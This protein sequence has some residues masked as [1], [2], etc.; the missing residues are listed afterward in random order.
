MFPLCIA[1]V[2]KTTGRKLDRENQTEHI[3]EV[4]TGGK[5]LISYFIYFAGNAELCEFVN[6]YFHSLFTQI[7]LTEFFLIRNYAGLFYV[8]FCTT[9]T[10]GNRSTFSEIYTIFNVKIKFDHLHRISSPNDSCKVFSFKGFVDLIPVWNSPGYCVT[11]RSS[12]I[13]YRD[14]W[15]FAYCLKYI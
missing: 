2:I 10:Q 12:S 5:Y 6:R 3:L 1:G 8:S 13:S 11:V 14:A 9:L 15:I 7:L 4:S